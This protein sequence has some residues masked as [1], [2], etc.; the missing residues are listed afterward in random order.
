MAKEPSEA[1]QLILE[2]N[3]EQTPCVWALNHPPEFQ[4]TEM[5]LPFMVQPNSPRKSTNAYSH[6]AGNA[7]E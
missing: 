6:Q 3:P 2:S 5:S 4:H 7:N 1:H